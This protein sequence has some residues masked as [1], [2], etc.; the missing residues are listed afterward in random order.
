M[1]VLYWQGNQAHL[2]QWTLAS[3]LLAEQMK[4]LLFQILMALLLFMFLKWKYLE[5]Q[6][7]SYHSFIAKFNQ[8]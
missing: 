3:L 7:F 1:K 5:M 4:S 2:I 8:H 6:A